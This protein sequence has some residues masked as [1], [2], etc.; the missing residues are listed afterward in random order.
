MFHLDTSVRQPTHCWIITSVSLLLIIKVKGSTYHI[1]PSLNNS[2][3]QDVN[4]CLILSELDT[5][6]ANRSDSNV[7]L[8][9]IAGYHS[10]TSHLTFQNLTHFSMTSQDNSSTVIYC[11]T[12]S[13]LQFQ[14]IKQVHIQGINFHG[15]SENRLTAVQEFA[16][17]DLIFYSPQSTLPNR[18]RILRV[19][20]STGVI[21]N[22]VFQAF[23]TTRWTM[24]AINISQSYASISD[25][26]F[27]GYNAQSGGAIYSTQS[28]S[29]I[30]NCTFV[31]NSAI[32]GGAIHTTNGIILITNSSFTKNN[33]TANGGAL[34]SKSNTVTDKDLSAHFRQ[35]WIDSYSMH[36]NYSKQFLI[37][38]H[39][40][41]IVCVSSNF[42]ENI[43][44]TNGGVIHTMNDSSLY[45]DRSYFC[46]NTAK[47]GGVL[48]IK[49]SSVLIH[50]SGFLNNEAKRIG[51]VGTFSK[52][53]VTITQ[54]MFSHNQAGE[55]SGA[56]HLSEFTNSTINS[57]IFHNN[58]AKYFGGCLNIFKGTKALLIGSITFEHSSARYGG[59][60]NMFDATIICNGSLTI[61]NNNGSISTAHSKGL[62]AG[63][64]T[65]INNRGSLYFFDSDVTISGQLMSTHHS[66]FMKQESDYTNE[67]GSLTL[68]ISRVKITGIVLLHNNKATNG[69][70]ILSITSR[71]VLEKIGSLFVSNNSATDTGGG[72]YLYHSE[73]Y[74]Q[75]VIHIYSNK[76]RAFGGG[77]HCI[78]SAIVIIIIDRRK[79][80]ISLKNNTA[81]SGGGIC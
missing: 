56:L 13:Q 61:S 76:A 17:K 19:I 33:A 50:N 18:R 73:L 38:K 23:V 69:G 32:N 60:F 14:A 46:F 80:L 7:S 45:V 51:G 27:T 48:R 66:R 5:S 72:I 53:T 40:V 28:F 75:G 43:A 8:I 25:S 81:N 24:G 42:S 31:K 59:A 4:S 36:N 2:W 65:L 16:L 37:G 71:I 41:W 58:R 10:L 21:S 15:C 64:L 3:C 55:R 12:T 1:S 67:G 22:T 26:T 34:F 70:G 9:F 44:K 39:S 11:Q 29:Q 63:N 77:I 57:G 49:A 74:V 62:F 6:F 20:K 47:Y 79:T 52:S 68:F 35:Q 78:S 30:S 54:S